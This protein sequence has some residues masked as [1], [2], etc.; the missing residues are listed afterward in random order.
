MEGEAAD[1]M[2]TNATTIQGSRRS[3]ADLQ[4]SSVVRVERPK[5]PPEFLGRGRSAVVYRDR[6]H[7]GRVTARKIFNGDRASTLVHYLLSGAPNPYGWNE[8]AVKCA[9]LRRSIAEQLVRY[10]FGNDLAVAPAHDVQWNGEHGAFE[11]STAFVKGRPARLRHPLSTASRGEMRDLQH[12]LMR[13]LQQRLAEAGFD[14]LVWQAGRGNPVAANNFLRDDAHGR[15]SWIDLESGVPALFPINPLDL[16][17]FYLPRSWRHRRPLFDDVD[18]E[19]LQA[20]VEAHASGIERCCGPVATTTLR[21]QITDLERH[22]QLWRSMKRVQRS[23]AHRLRKGAITEKEA[24]WYARRPVRWTARELARG[25]RSAARGVGRRIASAARRVFRIDYA[26]AAVTGWRFATSQRFRARVA[27]RYVVGRIDRWSRRGHLQPEETRSYRTRL[28]RE[29]R[30]SYLTDFGVH[31]TIKP[32]VK[33]VQW[34]LLPLLLAVGAIGP[35]PASLVLVFGGMAARS[36]YTSGRMA[37]A[38]MAG[39]RLPWVAL[40]VGLLPVVGNSAYP[41]QIVADG[42]GEGDPLAGFILFDTITAIGEHVPV[43]GGPDTA[44]EHYFNRL[45]EVLVRPRLGG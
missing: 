24:Q 41:A 19:K 44:T 23:I 40:M 11:L 22:Q 37:Q 18:I 36:I 20:Y 39:Q 43:W 13:P 28:H 12:R 4:G 8:D 2:P 31:L 9:A 17:R 32:A 26:A 29:D 42:A 7:T 35:V 6:D 15:W 10:W 5:N 45:A 1:T 30:G 3:L 33:T 21:R 25:C 14:G 27:R 16:L 38:A 34:G